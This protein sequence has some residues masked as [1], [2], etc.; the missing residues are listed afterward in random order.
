MK[1]SD[2]IHTVE[3]S[4]N[5]F[6]GVR[7]H[8]KDVQ[9]TEVQWRNNPNSQSALSK[10]LRGLPHSK[11]GQCDSNPVKWDNTKGKAAGCDPRAECRNMEMGGV[12]C[13]CTPPLKEKFPYDGSQCMK[14]NFEKICAEA[15]IMLGAQTLKGQAPTGLMGESATTLT[16]SLGNKSDGYTVRSLPLQKKQEAIVRGGQSRLTVEDVGKLQLDLMQKNESLCTLVPEL[17]IECDSGLE[18]LGSKC[19][20]APGM[21]VGGVG[22]PPGHNV[23]FSKCRQSRKL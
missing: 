22:R 20:A 18:Q 15:S 13:T 17:T 5:R 2:S 11:M 3:A 7:F 4:L 14:P 21:R 8:V 16:V 10:D 12:Q 19:K 1:I 23:D 9:K 6:A